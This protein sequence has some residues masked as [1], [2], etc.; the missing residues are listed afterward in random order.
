MRRHLAP[1]PPQPSGNVR[2]TPP[3]SPPPVLSVVTFI[4][5]SSPPPALL[6]HH[7]P[8]VSPGHR[9][10]FLRLSSAAPAPLPF[11]LAVTGAGFWSETRAPPLPW[12]VSALFLLGCSGVSLRETPSVFVFVL[13]LRALIC[14]FECVCA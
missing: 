4:L 13:V 2:W 3:P 7:L 11:P 14:F 9:P 12:P 1:P 10:P 5:P 8:P 6:T